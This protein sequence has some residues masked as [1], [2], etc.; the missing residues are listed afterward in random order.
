MNSHAVQ[1]TLAAHPC[2][3]QY[4]PSSLESEWFH[5]SATG[6][7]CEIGG[8]QFAAVEPWLN[9][10]TAVPPRSRPTPAEARVLSRFSCTGRRDSYIE[11]LSG[12]ARH[13]HAS[14]GCHGFNHNLLDISYIVP[15]NACAAQD[16]G[17]GGLPTGNTARARPRALL[18]DMWASEPI[19]TLTVGTHTLQ[20][21]VCP[22][23]W[24]AT[25][26]AVGSPRT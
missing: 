5:R 17:Q 14:V 9:F 13:P 4:T 7:I 11:P 8:A 26:A 25:G 1:R 16:K 12:V 22:C 10:S 24:R 20:L 18:Y 23:V 15:F 6:R 19:R 3:G 2:H 21:T